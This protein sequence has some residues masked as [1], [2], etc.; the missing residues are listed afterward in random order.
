MNEFIIVTGMS[1]A[2]K[3]RAIAVLE[4]IGYYCVDNMPPTLLPVFA[5]LCRQSGDKLSRVAL[6]MDARGGELFKDQLDALDDLMGKFRDY[7]ILFLDCDD[8]ELARRF[9]ETRRGH[10]LAAQCGGSVPKAI[11]RERELLKGV[12]SRADY[13]I[14]T[15]LLSPAQLKERLVQLFETAR[16]DVM[17]VQCLSFGF[18]YGYPAEADMVLD[19]RC[20]PNPYYVDK[21]KNQT[22][23]DKEVRDYVLSG[24]ET[25]GLVA[26]MYAL[27]D[28]LL[29]L[30]QK[31]GKSQFVI[32][33][34]CTGGKHR[35]VTLAEELAAH[36]REQGYRAMVN[37]RDIGKIN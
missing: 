36:I 2:G 16:A 10:P 27:V 25:A 30:Y 4:D 29:P 12:L 33:L 7:K 26:R 8:A 9:K 1:G 20:L 15:S 17:A 6:V 28:Y 18:K 22:G 32:A 35:S 37:H 31:E 19:V 24:D 34:G 14:D 23:L 11:E 13:R 3:S 5:D 21:L